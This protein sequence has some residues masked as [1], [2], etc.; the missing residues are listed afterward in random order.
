MEENA[1]LPVQ[2]KSKL[3]QGTGHLRRDDLFAGGT[4]ARQPLQG[5]QMMLF[6]TGGIPADNGDFTLLLVNIRLDLM[7]DESRNPRLKAEVRFCLR[8]SWKDE[9]T[10]GGP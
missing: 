10:T 2:L 9:G 7:R 8:K 5:R 1:D 3:A 4:L 6:Q